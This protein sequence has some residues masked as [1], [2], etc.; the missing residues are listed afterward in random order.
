MSEADIPPADAEAQRL[1]QHRFDR[2][3]HDLRFEPS[4]AERLAMLGADWHTAESLLLNGCPH[5]L[6]LELLS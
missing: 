2:F 4:E 6:V 3:L 5:R 1:Y